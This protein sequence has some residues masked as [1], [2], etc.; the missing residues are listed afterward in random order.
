MKVVRVQLLLTGN[1]L[2]SG[3]TVDSNG[4]KTKIIKEIKIKI[5]TKSIEAKETTKSISNVSLNT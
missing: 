2:M 5:M 3:V 1:E 4:K